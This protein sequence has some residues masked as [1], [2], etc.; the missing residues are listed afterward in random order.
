MVWHQSFLLNLVH[1]P[2]NAYS[3]VV[4]ASHS[5]VSYRC[6][7][8]AYPTEVPNKI[9]GL[10]VQNAS[11]KSVTPIGVYEVTVK[12]GKK[13]FTHSFII[14]KELTSTVILGLDFSS[15]FQIGS[16]WTQ[17]GTIYIHQ[18]K[19]KLIEGT[20]KG[21]ANDIS[22]PQK[23]P[24]LVLKTHVTLTPYTLS[25]V[26]VRITNPEVVCSDQYLMSNV[27]PLFKAQYPD[28]AVI[29]LMHHTMDKNP[30]T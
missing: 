3:T 30:K 15:R 20:N 7:K 13:N 19:L 21:D 28:I 24:C 25:V 22:T 29:P 2:P 8:S 5:C 23:R 27:D 1:T 26:P 6:F 12:L 11:G 18:G 4:L 14:C 10:S 17:K 9:D 16:D